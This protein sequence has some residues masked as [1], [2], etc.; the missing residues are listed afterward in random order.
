MIVQESRLEILDKCYSIVQ[1]SSAKGGIS[2]K[3]V[4]KK[5][6]HRSTAHGY[7]N[8]LEYV[9]KVESQHGR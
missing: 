9:G 2:A 6:V 8:T 7:L 5:G 3:E 1:Q 4:G